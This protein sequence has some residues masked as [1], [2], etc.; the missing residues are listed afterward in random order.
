MS[1]AGVEYD[2]T[3][4]LADLRPIVE[5]EASAADKESDARDLIATPR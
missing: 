4:N 3:R 5:G 2:F 1:Q